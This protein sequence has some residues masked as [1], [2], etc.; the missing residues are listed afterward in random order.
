MKMQILITSLLIFHF[1]IQAIDFMKMQIELKFQCNEVK[2]SAHMELEGWKRSMTFLRD[3]VN[4]SSLVT[5]RHFMVK[6]YTRWTPRQ[7]HYFDVWHIAKC[8][9]NFNLQVRQ[10]SLICKI[11]LHNATEVML[12]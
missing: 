6:K 11:D 5:D 7:K 10:S 9:S 12:K 2:W 8:I 1:I 3:H 4:V